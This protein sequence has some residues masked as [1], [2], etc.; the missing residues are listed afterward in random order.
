MSP[1]RSRLRRINTSGWR[2]GVHSHHNWIGDTRLPRFLAAE[3]AEAIA[4]ERAAV[5]A[6]ELPECIKHPSPCP[7]CHRP[8][9][10][11]SHYCRKCC[12]IICPDCYDREEG[13]CRECLE[14]ATG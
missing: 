11:R 7:I 14:E 10:I 3:Q 8:L 13:Q 12:R 5:L 9:P 4:A 6:E 2:P 1:V